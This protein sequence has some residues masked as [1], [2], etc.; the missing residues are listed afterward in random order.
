M[1][2]PHK[3]PCSYFNQGWNDAKKS[4]LGIPPD[5]TDQQQRWYNEGYRAYSLH[6]S[7]RLTT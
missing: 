6:P 5:A 3:R 7:R 4:L 2:K 1:S